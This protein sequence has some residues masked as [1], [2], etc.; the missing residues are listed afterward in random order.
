MRRKRRFISGREA[1]GMMGICLK[2]FDLTGTRDVDLRRLAGNA[3][4]TVCVVPWILAVLVN[5]S[6]SWGK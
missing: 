3:Y 4:A 1:C 6:W 5:F 2:G